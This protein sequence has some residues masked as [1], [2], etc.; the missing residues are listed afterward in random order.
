M[1]NLLLAALLALPLPLVAA[2]PAA[3]TAQ[4]EVRRNGEPMGSATVTFSAQGG[5]AYE[6]R[7]HTVG[8]GGL[9]A[10]AGADIDERSVL[11]WRNGV[12]ETRRYSYRQKVAWKTK[13][14][15]LV[16]DAD[17][18]R[19]DSRDGDKSYSPPYEPGVLD[20]HAVNIALMQDLA[21]GASGDRVYRVP[22]RDQIDTQRYRVAGR[23]SLQTA[24]GAQPVLRV[25]RIRDS[26]DGRKTTVW[27]GSGQRYIPLRMLQTES[28]G[29]SV[30][31]R[32]V[33]IR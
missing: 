2:A 31:M 16:V 20:R 1:R 23:E 24:M 28:N 13:E 9:A 14:R 32:I 21:A 18:G 17:A 3:Y 25:E 19:I 11:G 12:P 6:L 15:S 8:T 10:M 30:E 5:G 29:D 7:T 22:Q 33:S 26:D 27:F 4:Y